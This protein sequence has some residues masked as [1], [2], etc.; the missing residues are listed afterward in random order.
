M[1]RIGEKSMVKVPS[2]TGITWPEIAP[3][4]R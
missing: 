1:V 4:S 3:I 2:I